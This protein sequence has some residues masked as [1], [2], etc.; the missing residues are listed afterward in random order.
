[1]ISLLVVNYRSA[2][3]AVDAVRSARAATKDALHVVIVDNSCDETEAS[4]LRSHADVLL[5]SPRNLGYAGAINFGRPHCRGEIAIVTN[6]DVLFFASAIDE[7][8][9]ALLPPARAVA[10]PA[11]YWDDG[12]QWMLPPSDRQNLRG[13]IDEIVASRWAAWSRMRDRRRFQQRFRF[14]TLTGT[15]PVDALSGAVMAIRL[16]DF[17]EI[18]GF[19]ER[20]ALYF[21]E[22]DFLRRLRRKRREI[23]YVPAAQ[24][25]H[26]YNQSAGAEESRA[27]AL[28]EA[29]GQLYY[30]KWYGRPIARALDRL[31]RPLPPWPAESGTT[32][33]QLPR[34]G[35]VVEAS[36]LASFSTAAGH[37]ASSTTVALP[38][39]V[40]RSFRGTGL[41]LRV[42]DPRSA[43]VLS[44]CS[45]T[46]FLPEKS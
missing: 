41:Y 2:A 18:G 13:K 26:V 33:L 12:R 20:F 19:D 29:S 35:L 38:A 36:P 24:C 10:G 8:A 44:A 30:A 17:D 27:A 46:S 25:R 37:L 16:R 45:V 1:M 42:V 32:T 40:L 39:E 3:L 21:E 6:P 34:P 23:A 22:T 4:A 9:A 31:A 14:W 15:T 43:E 28:Y 7:L 5:V 11:L